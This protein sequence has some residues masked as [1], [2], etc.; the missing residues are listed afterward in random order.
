MGVVALDS[1]DFL[2]VL[3]GQLY[4]WNELIEDRTSLVGTPFDEWG[5]STKNTLRVVEPARSEWNTPTANRSARIR[6]TLISDISS[7]DANVAELGL[8]SFRSRPN[9]ARRAT[10]SVKEAPLKGTLTDPEHPKNAWQRLFDEQ[11]GG[12]RIEPLITETDADTIINHP[13]RL[14]RAETSWDMAFQHLCLDVAVDRPS[15]KALA[16]ARNGDIRLVQAA[17]HL[18][19]NGH[20]Y[21]QLIALLLALEYMRMSLYDKAHQLIKDAWKER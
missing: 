18:K 20:C 10:A 15:L 16:D 5:E 3:P 11:E 1:E 14:A 13:K 17:I 6:A 19:K 2:H 21:K 9:R 12:N 4:I 7:D 8:P